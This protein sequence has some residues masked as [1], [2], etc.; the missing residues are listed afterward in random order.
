MD[1]LLSGLDRGLRTM[2]A[3]QT[4]SARPSPGNAHPDAELSESERR[5]VAGLMRINHAGE[6]AAQALYQSQALTARDRQVAER[7]QAA[8]DEEVDHL[9]WCGARLEELG[10]GPSKLTP[11]WYTGAFTIGTV[12]GAFGDR[13]NLGFVA[14]TERQVCHHLEDHMGRLPA[15]DKRS[16][17]ILQQ[18]HTEEDEHRENALNEG[19]S[20]LPAPVRGMMWAASRVMTTLAYRL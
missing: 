18:M 10:E 19:G 14:E 11:V 12:A 3:G 9:A 1:Q 8:A 2:F 13:W 7:M 5:H 4:R 6:V 20:E 17:A 15:Q 16:R